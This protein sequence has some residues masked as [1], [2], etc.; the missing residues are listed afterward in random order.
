M[1]AIMSCPNESSPMKNALKY[2]MLVLA[3]AFPIAAFAA[4]VGILPLATFFF[5]ETAVFGFAIIG[6]MAIGLSDNG[7][8]QPI[9][10]HATVAPAGQSTPPIPTRRSSAYGIHRRE[11]ATA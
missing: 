2:T 1:R 10:V 5:S 7:R 8:R 9:C 6:L 11:R 4:L 3:V